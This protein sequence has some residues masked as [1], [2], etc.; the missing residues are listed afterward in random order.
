[1][2]AVVQTCHGH[3]HLQALRHDDLDLAS[4][5]GLPVNPV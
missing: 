1:M 5:A 3:G 4:L 2:V